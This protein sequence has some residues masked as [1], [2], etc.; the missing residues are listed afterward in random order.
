M[1]GLIPPASRFL[2]A[3]Q[4]RNGFSFDDFQILGKN[5]ILVAHLSE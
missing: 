2:S 5:N 3:S 4:A 1:A